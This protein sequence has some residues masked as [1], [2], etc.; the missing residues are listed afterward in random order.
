LERVGN[1]KGPAQTVL[2]HG[3]YESGFYSVCCLH[4]SG[5]LSGKRISVT[6]S[7][8]FCRYAMQFREASK[9]P[10]GARHSASR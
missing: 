1:S 2:G 4:I 7:Y 8:L 10:L 5:A 3:R 6:L 9:F